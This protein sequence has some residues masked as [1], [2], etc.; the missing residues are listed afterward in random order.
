[1]DKHQDS[2]YP[3]IKSAI[4][5]SLSPVARIAH[6]SYHQVDNAILS[7]LG[8]T[9]LD[10][11]EGERRN[12]DEVSCAIPYFDFRRTKSALQRRR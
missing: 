2:I 5:Q 10:R 3:R 4:V 9:Q 7:Q 1:M 12:G 11:S 8:Q 6:G